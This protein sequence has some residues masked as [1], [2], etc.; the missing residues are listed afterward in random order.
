MSE[1]KTLKGFYIKHRSSDPSDP[2]AGEIWYNSTTQTL[3]IA[4]QIGAWAS[5]GDMAGSHYALGGCGTQTAMLGAGGYAPASPAP[6][7]LALSEEYDGTTW[8]EGNNIGTA[9][10][11]MSGSGT[12]TAGLIASGVASDGGTSHTPSADTEE[13]NG[14]SWSEQNNTGTVHQWG[15]AAGTQTATLLATGRTAPAVHTNCENY[16][17]TSWTEG[18]DVNTGRYEVYGF[19]TSTAMVIAGGTA[20]GLQSIVEEFDGSSWTEVTN[21][22]AVRTSAGGSGILTSGIVYGGANTTVKLDTALTY[23]GT[24]WAASPDMAAAS[25]HGN[26][27]STESNNSQAIYFGR[28][29]TSYIDKTEE[30]TV[31]ATVRTVDT[32]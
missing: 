29:P 2:I 23:D 27:G 14:T 31:A 28:S 24:N 11:N 16:D 8:T 18:P 22:P 4:P 1:F 25:A 30:W 9:R 10:Y 6:G 15:T 26:R 20:P 3:K 5:G 32:S 7:V 19:G 12:Q 13:Y 21:L 17:G